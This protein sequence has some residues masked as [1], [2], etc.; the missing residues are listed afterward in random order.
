VEL[1][2]A[3]LTTHVQVETAH[4]TTVKKKVPPP[5]DIVYE[6]NM[7]LPSEKK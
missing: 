4:I 5:K 7:N 6:F 1:G 3:N 2:A